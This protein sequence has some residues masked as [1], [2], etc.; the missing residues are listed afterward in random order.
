MFEGTIS[1]CTLYMYEILGMIQIPREKALVA[2]QH[3][4]RGCYDNWMIWENYLLVRLYCF[5][6][7]NFLSAPGVFGY[8][9]V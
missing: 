9:R 1:K 7:V 5:P 4:I 2:Y 3:A 8:W 6:V